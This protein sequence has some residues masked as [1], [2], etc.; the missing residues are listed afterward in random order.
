MNYQRIQQEHIDYFKSI[1]PEDCIYVIDEAHH[2]AAS[3]RDFL[4]GQAQLTDNA[5][6]LEKLRKSLQQAQSILRHYPND[7]DMTRAAE[8]TPDVFQTQMEPVTRLFAQYQQNKEDKN[9]GS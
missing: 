5:P 6:W 4:M 9:N 7:W 1:S 8:N 2:L 3:G